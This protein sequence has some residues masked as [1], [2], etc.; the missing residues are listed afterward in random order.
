MECREIRCYSH[1][2]DGSITKRREKVYSEQIH[3]V[4]LYR[5]DDESL[6]RSFVRRTGCTNEIAG[7]LVFEDSRNVPLVEREGRVLSSGDEMALDVMRSMFSAM[8][9]SKRTAPAK[10]LTGFG[11]PPE[12]EA[13]ESPRHESQSMTTEVDEKLVDV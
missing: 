2:S 12:S 7:G 1:T 11:T 4:Y 13:V 9:L 10:M 6:G 3:P 8:G 5:P